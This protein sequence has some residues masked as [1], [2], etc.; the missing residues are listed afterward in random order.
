[1]FPRMN[2]QWE[3]KKVFMGFDAIC[4]GIDPVWT[5]RMLFFCQ[6]ALSLEKK[7]KIV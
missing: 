1:M 7:E 2:F 4:M 3:L 6:R 5:E